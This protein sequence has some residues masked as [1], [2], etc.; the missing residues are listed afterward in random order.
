MTRDVKHLLSS[1]C[2]SVCFGWNIIFS[3]IISYLIYESIILNYHVLDEGISKH[4]PWK[5]GQI[6]HVPMPPSDIN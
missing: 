5:R 2:P 1:K 4:L 6:F 3:K